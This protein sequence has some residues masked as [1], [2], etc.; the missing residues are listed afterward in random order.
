MWRG[1]DLSA[2]LPAYLPVRPPISLIGLSAQ[3][4]FLTEET[5]IVLART[6]S[7][8]LSQTWHTVPLIETELRETQQ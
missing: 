3:C 2:C 8:L 7:P 5:V 6:L 1:S 4:H